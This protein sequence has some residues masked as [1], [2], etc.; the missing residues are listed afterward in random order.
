MKYVGI[1]Q[2]LRLFADETFL[3]SLFNTIWYML[4]SLICNLVLALLLAVVLNSQLVRFKSGFRAIYFLPIVTST[5][6]AAIMF[7]LIYD[8]DY[9]LLNVPLLLLE[10]KP[11]NWLGSTDLS[12]IAVI[13]VIVWRWVGFNMIYFLAGLQTIPQELY[14][15]AEIDGAT[16]VKKFFYITLPLLKPII[17]LVSVLTLIGSSQLFEEP[18]ILTQGGPADSSLSIAQYLYRSGMEYLN[19][20]YA[21]AIGFFLF[22]M[23][24]FLSWF[25]IKTQGTFKE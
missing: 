14:E 22:G 23:I 12:K 6:A 25:Q 10:K 18:Y 15:V 13:G 16:R 21:A 8:K 5:V 17:L 20:G 2:Y 4:A 24:F 3:L 19:L 11:L 1:A 9:G 7:T